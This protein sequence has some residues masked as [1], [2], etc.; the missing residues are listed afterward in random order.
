MPIVGKTASDVGKKLVSNKQVF[1]VLVGSDCLSIE[2]MNGVDL[3]RLLKKLFEQTIA[4]KDVTMRDDSK[5]KSNSKRH[6]KS[7]VDTHERIGTNK[8]KHRKGVFNL[9]NSKKQHVTVTET[10]IIGNVLILN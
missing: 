8:C 1:S 5:T 6:C 7:L 9:M 3:R 2:C 10:D 4:Y